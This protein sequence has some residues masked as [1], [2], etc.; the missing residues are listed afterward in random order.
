MVDLPLDNE[1]RR[2]H[3][4]LVLCEECNLEEV[5]VEVPEDLKKTGTIEVEAVCLPQYYPERFVVRYNCACVCVCV[6][7]CVYVREKERERERG[8][9]VCVCEI[10]RGRDYIYTRN[11]VHI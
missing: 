1:L 2:L 4:W 9:C 3:L 5:V 11:K 8:V 6:C 7:V 10:E